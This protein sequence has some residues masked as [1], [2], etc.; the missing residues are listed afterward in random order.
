MTASS[1]HFQ[2]GECHQARVMLDEAIRHTP[3]V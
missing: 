2:A 1:Y 3:P